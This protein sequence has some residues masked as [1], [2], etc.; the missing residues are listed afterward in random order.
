MKALQ[1]TKSVDISRL[2]NELLTAVPGTSPVNGQAVLLLSYDAATSTVKMWVPDAVDGT[3]VATTVAA[4]VNLPLPGPT[5]AD[6][7]PDPADLVNQGGSAVADMRTYLANIAPT[8]LQTVII[9]KLMIRC[10]LTL[11]QRLG[12]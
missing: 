4:H 7:G 2:H 11:M 12:V 3:L 9:V 6:Y 5:P 1:Y 8:N 10:L